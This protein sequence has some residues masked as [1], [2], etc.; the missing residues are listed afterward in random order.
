[1]QFEPFHRGWL[2]QVT[3]LLGLVRPIETSEGLVYPASLD[4]EFA[5]SRLFCM[6]DRQEFLVARPL[7]VEINVVL[8]NGSQF[9][10]RVQ[11]QAM[12]GREIK[13]ARFIDLV[14]S[15]HQFKLNLANLMKRFK[16]ALLSQRNSVCGL[17]PRDGEACRLNPKNPILEYVNDCSLS[18]SFVVEKIEEYVGLLGDHIETSLSTDLGLV[19]NDDYITAVRDEMFAS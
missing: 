12:G 4:P 10:S 5:R 2:K 3:K 16:E 9:L 8:I 19:N 14:K 6:A 11:A 13:L 7:A 15:V 17:P 1:M 18:D